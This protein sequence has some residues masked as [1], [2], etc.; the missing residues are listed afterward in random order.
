[1]NIQK[2]MMV[3]II[4]RDII[5]IV[6]QATIKTHRIDIQKVMM[7]DKIIR[8]LIPILLIINITKIQNIK[9]E[10]NLNNNTK[11]NFI[12]EEERI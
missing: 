3:G 5:K 12:I 7:A 2:V 4:S 11:S 8:V 1:M 9:K 6:I 10:N